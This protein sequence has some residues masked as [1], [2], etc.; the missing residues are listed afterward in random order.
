ML[1]L[2][3]RAC[4]SPRSCLP[5]TMYAPATHALPS[6]ALPCQTTASSTRAAWPSV[7]RRAAVVPRAVS[8]DVEK[9]NASAAVPVKIAPLVWEEDKETPKQLMAFSGPA[10]ERSKWYS[11]QPWWVCVQM[12]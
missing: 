10:P 5:D 2:P 6:Y 1:N 7:P 8:S 4:P 9:S 3:C 11:E 12:G